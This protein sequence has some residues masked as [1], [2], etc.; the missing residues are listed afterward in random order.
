MSLIKIPAYAM[1]CLLR[2]MGEFWS[3]T[4]K[5]QIDFIYNSGI[6]TGEAVIENLDV[7]ELN[8]HNQNMTTWLHRFIRSCTLSELKL[9][10]RFVT[11][12]ATFVSGGTIKVE[13]VNQHPRNLFPIAATCFK[14]YYVYPVNIH[15]S[16]ICIAIFWN[17]L[18]ATNSG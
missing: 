3:G 2:G 11:G 9:L 15:H 12:S 18:I 17:I 16:I 10:L 1:K 6:T 13:Y 5:N 14:K 8:N 7:T 4:N